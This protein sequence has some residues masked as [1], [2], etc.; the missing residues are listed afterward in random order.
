M[1]L[2]PA[3]AP[4][5]RQRPFSFSVI[6]VLPSGIPGHPISGRQDKSAAC[7]RAHVVGWLE[8]FGHARELPCRRSRLNP[9][10]LQRANRHRMLSRRRG[11]PSEGR[12]DR[13]C[14]Y[15]WTTTDHAADQRSHGQSL[16]HLPIRYVSR[17]ACDLSS[18][19]RQFV[20]PCCRVRPIFV[21][22][23]G[24]AP[25]GQH[26]RWPPTPHVGGK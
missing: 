11:G 12:E 19:S 5:P 1:R 17:S 4:W 26:T 6:A 25:T 2:H 13:L 20:A 18:R 7:G 9:K 23:E 16:A 14:A 22:I 21:H 15:A 10:Q 3:W 24:S 8:V